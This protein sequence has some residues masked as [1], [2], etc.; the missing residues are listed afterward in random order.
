M[1]VVGAMVEQATPF[2]PDGPQGR[3]IQESTTPFAG[4]H[5][6]SVAMGV[7][8]AMV[9][10]ATPIGPDGPQGR[11][12][13]ESN[14]LGPC[15]LRD[16]PPGRAPQG[17]TTQLATCDG[18]RHARRRRSLRRVNGYGP[19]DGRSRGATSAR[20]S[21]ARFEYEP[22][23]RRRSSWPARQAGGGGN[24]RTPGPSERSE[25]TR[26]N[27]PP[28]DGRLRLCVPPRGWLRLSNLG[29]KGTTERA[30]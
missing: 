29:A 30:A 10:Q 25:P 20:D 15:G 11:A 13:Q 24:D 9:E 17:L 19:R 28:R 16:V 18:V 26:G 22:A 12:T 3:A 1:G 5:A 27:P 4:W 21:S 8:G 23:P 2:G 6:Q 7:V 14:A